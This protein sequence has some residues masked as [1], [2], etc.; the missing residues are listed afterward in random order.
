MGQGIVPL[1]EHREPAERGEREAPAAFARLAS[2]ELPR[3][4]RDVALEARN[5]LVLVQ[6]YLERLEERYDDEQFR[7]ELQAVIGE[8]GGRIDTAVRRLER[9]A[10]DESD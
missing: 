5:V 4:A 1:E 3:I 6:A 9:A 8:V 7:A 2:S 10:E